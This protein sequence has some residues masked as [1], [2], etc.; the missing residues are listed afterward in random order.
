MMPTQPLRGA[1]RCGRVTAGLSRA[2]L[3]GLLLWLVPRA[4]AQHQGPG[5]FA[6]AGT[7]TL[8]TDGSAADLD[9]ANDSVASSNMIVRNIY[10]TLLSLDG[11]SIDR[12]KPALAV[13]WDVNPRKSLY[14]FHLRHGVRFHTGRCCL[15][16]ADVQYSLQRLVLSNLNEA[17][18]LARFL[19]DPLKQI[20]VRD[21]YTVAFAL[22]RPQPF[23]LA[24]LASQYAPYILDAQALKAHEQ[25]HDWG[26][27][28][29]SD[30]D[31]GT[32]PYLLQSWAH[33]QQE[34]LVRFPAYWGGWSGAHFSRVIVRTVP[35]A[36][37]RRELVERGAA[38]LT[39]DL[40]PQDYQALSTNPAVKV[41]TPYGTDIDYI[42][43]TEWGPLA[44]PY[45]RQA[46]S[47][48]FPYDALIKGVLRGYAQR[49]YGPLARTVLGY[50]PHMF[51][52]QTD[53][54]KARALLQK[55]GVKPG[56]TL[57]YTYADPYGPLGLL[58]QAQLAQ[59]GITLKLQRLDEAVFSTIFYGSEPASKRPNLMPWGWWPDY[60]DPYDECVPLVASYSYNAGNAGYYHNAAVDA[61][62]ADMK[63]A[64]RERVV[65]DAYKL[66]DL[67][68]RVDPSAIWAY[69]PTDVT[70]MVKNLQGYVF[71]PL[72]IQTYGF[73]TMYRS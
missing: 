41:S 20:T 4:A 19:T 58:L 32:G 48:A 61:L 11:S 27:A 23:F 5:S 54:S 36:A 62:L 15:T 42:D 25:Q 6:D 65:S 29:A 44:S 31:A 2:L 49:A 73:Y 47:Y 71:N 22:G 18:V 59:V 53:L 40:T 60:N 1:D 30:H 7:V 46:L 51:H 52:Y 37:T 3:L 69:Q 13:A 68:G 64:A 63:T 56:T 28:W 45:A 9:P 50:D 12:Y 17:Y 57:T 33:S 26:H 16:A 8:V 38:D 39:F 24:G 14:T 67:T 34:V 35:A 55:A 10:D 21:P 66:Q 70:I 43:M 72:A